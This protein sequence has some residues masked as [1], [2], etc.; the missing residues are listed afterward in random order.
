[1]MKK[2]T[3]SNMRLEDIRRQELASLF[4]YESAQRRMDEEITALDKV[5]TEIEKWLADNIEPP[6]SGKNTGG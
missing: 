1:M 4:P 5:K 3:M 2:G 6:E